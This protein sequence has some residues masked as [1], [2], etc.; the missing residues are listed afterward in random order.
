MAERWC[1]ARHTATHC[2]DSPRF[3]QQFVTLVPTIWCSGRC[4]GNWRRHRGSF[5]EFLILKS[6]FVSKLNKNREMQ[7]DWKALNTNDDEVRWE[8]T[9]FCFFYLASEI[10]LCPFLSGLFLI[11][12]SRCWKKVTLT[13][14][15]QIGQIFACWFK[16]RAVILSCVSFSYGYLWFETK[17]SGVFKEGCS[18]SEHYLTFPSPLLGWGCCSVPPQA[19][20]HREGGGCVLTVDSLLSPW[21]L[22]INNKVSFYF[23]GG[24]GPDRR[25]RVINSERPAELLPGAQI[26]WGLFTH[27][28]IALRCC[29]LKVMTNKARLG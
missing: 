17:H 28:V 19:G 4:Q 5:S 1:E 12:W 15:K 29:E 24:V 20:V 3:P 2:V 7:L 25:W 11:V 6:D 9:K 27:P 21:L 16:N 8:Q 14:V 13:S 22:H 26:D 23:T 18:S 10:Y